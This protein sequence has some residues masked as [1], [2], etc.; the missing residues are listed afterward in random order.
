MNFGKFTSVK[1]SMLCLLI[2]AFAVSASADSYFKQLTYTGAMEMMGNTTPERYDTTETWLSKDRAY[3]ILPGDYA[4]LIKIDEGIGISINHNDSSYAEIPLDFDKLLSEATD[5]S[6]E[7][8]EAKKMAEQMMGQMEITVTPTEETKKI[9][10]WNTK[11]YILEIKM[12]MMG[13]KS[14]I[15]ATQ[16]IDIDY[17]LY[18]L[19]TNVM[20]ASMPGFEDLVSEYNKIKGIAVLGEGE[21]NMMGSKTT[22][23][24][25]LLEYKE[26]AAPAGIY[27]IPSGYKKIT[28][29]GMGK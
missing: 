23:S 12:G 18:Y 22:S 17:N 10:D 7:A 29:P 3:A 26:A 28:V 15:W 13:T 5:N 2:V 1:C 11:K 8:E 21:I 20:M 16:D 6:K 24:N 4:F 27:E 19:A 25:E 9:K 14:D